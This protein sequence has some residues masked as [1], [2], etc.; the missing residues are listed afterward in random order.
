M[1]PGIVEEMKYWAIR[2][3]RDD[4]DLENE[5]KAEIFKANA[6]GDTVTNAR[7]EA[8]FE[9]KRRELA[10]TYSK[11]LLP[12]LKSA[13]YLREELLRS[14]LMMEQTTEDNTMA[15]IFA[16]ALAGD[17]IQWRE[18]GEI[19]GY[20]DN[21]VKKFVTVPPSQIQAKIN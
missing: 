13:N 5:K 15:D 14:A 16:R 9:K 17:S 7:I 10:V 1:A 11:Q 21:L 6:L 18:M 12:L 3:N 19:S 2:W 8:P 20:M 4:R